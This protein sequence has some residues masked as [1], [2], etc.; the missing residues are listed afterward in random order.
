MDIKVLNTS[1]EALAIVDN[2]DSILWIERYNKH[3]EFEI[4]TQFSKY[5][6]TVLS[7]GHYLTIPESELTMIIEDVRIKTD[8]DTGPKLIFTGRSLASVLD[9]RIVL[10]KILVDGSFQTGIQN[11]LNADVIAS[12]YPERNFP[13]FIFSASSN[14]T[15]TA[16][17][18][19][20]QYYSENLL[21]LL[22]DLISQ[23]GIG[24]KVILNS[25]NQYVFS[26]YAGIDRSYAQG[27]NSFVVF[28]PEFDNLLNSEY[29]KTARYKKTFVLVHGSPDSSPEGTP[30]FPLR[31]QVGGVGGF[32]TGLNRKEM[33]VD[34]SSL[35]IYLEN[36]STRIPDVDYLAQLTQIGQNALAEH[37]EYSTFDGQVLLDRTYIYKQDFFLGDIIQIVDSYGNSTRSQ[38]MELTIFENLSGRATYPTLRTI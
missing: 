28:S 32:G 20:G 37:I 14:P 33:F 2:V 35:S 22:E 13:N 16:L 26:L 23:A 8:P 6:L 15:V 24:Y 30:G 1:F 21:T 34:A 5:F 18:L 25:T 3:G 19:K 27:T 9:R 29:F 11:I 38:I 17:T 7:I 10:R 31:T 36:S 12:I 4:Y